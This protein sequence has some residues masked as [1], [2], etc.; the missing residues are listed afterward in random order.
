MSNPYLT[1]FN[2]QFLEFI[3]DILRLFPNDKDIIATKN[4]LLMMKKMNPKLIITAWRDYIA[5]PYADDIENGGMEFFLNKDYSED[6]QQLGSDIDK[7]LKVI[8]R[9]RGPLKTLH[10]DDSTSA[11]KYIS[12]LTK[13]SL[14]YN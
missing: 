11:L 3:E 14:L 7:I 6:L 8:D 4:S 13:L 10:S 1:A 9:L 2:N 5:I 12:N